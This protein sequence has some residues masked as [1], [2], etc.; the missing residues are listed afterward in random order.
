MVFKEPEG[1]AAS[2]VGSGVTLVKN[3]YNFKTYLISVWRFLRHLSKNQCF[4]SE[5]MLRSIEQPPQ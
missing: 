5:M 3:I 2:R 4:Q 1:E